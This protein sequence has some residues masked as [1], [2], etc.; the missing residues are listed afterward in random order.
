MKL[1]I[2]FV[3][4]SFSISGC[5]FDQYPIRPTELQRTPTPSQ[6]A[7]E[8]LIPSYT[9][10]QPST[11]TPTI[12]PTVTLARFQLEDCNPVEPAFP[13][14]FAIQSNIA[15][16]SA[17]LIANYWYGDFYKA[18]LIAAL[19]RQEDGTI[20]R[21]YTVDVV[22]VPPPDS[23]ISLSFYAKYLSATNQEMG[24]EIIIEPCGDDFL[25]KPCFYTFPVSVTFD[26]AIRRIYGTNVETSVI[27]RFK[28]ANKLE[29]TED[30]EGGFPPVYLST[31]KVFL[32]DELIIIPREP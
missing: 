23:I 17:E 18:D 21:F 9:P 14:W 13:C 30:I 3:V 1:L 7:T 28:L 10:T 6:T 24:S 20:A 27:D 25:N 8:T 15:L 31:P 16:S 26:G 5:K 11:N 22:L 2:F 32:A 29:V 12:T 19:H 4:V